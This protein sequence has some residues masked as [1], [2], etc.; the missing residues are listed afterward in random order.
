[1]LRPLDV[2]VERLAGWHLPAVASHVR[3]RARD[4]GVVVS[5]ILDAQLASLHLASEMALHCTQDA[6]RPLDLRR[7]LPSPLLLKSPV[8]VCDEELALVVIGGLTL[9]DH[10]A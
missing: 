4:G 8:D 10:R 5:P 9:L 7:R 3:E 1:R 2:V 6:R